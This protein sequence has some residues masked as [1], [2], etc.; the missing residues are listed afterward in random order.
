MS[1]T[2]I[3]RNPLTSHSVEAWLDKGKSGTAR[4]HGLGVRCTIQ[5]LTNSTVVGCRMK[6]GIAYEAGC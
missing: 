3:K 2:L 1:P 6:C 4:E 5:F